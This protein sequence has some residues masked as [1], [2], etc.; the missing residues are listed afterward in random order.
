MRI[1]PKHGTPLVRTPQSPAG[2]RD[3]MTCAACNTEAL[4]RLAAQPGVITVV[5]GGAPGAPPMDAEEL[6]NWIA[7][8]GS[9]RFLHPAEQQLAVHALRALAAGQAPAGA[10][11][12]PAA[13]PGPSGDVAA[14]DRPAF[15][16][17][18]LAQGLIDLAERCEH[19]ARC[20]TAVDPRTLLREAAIALRAVAVSRTNSRTSGAALSN[21]L[22]RDDNPP[23][24]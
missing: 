17:H 20:D 21:A 16:A 6:A 5:A 3:L 12:P 11:A 14:I 22:N 7:L 19:C 18:R 24:K 23:L 1:C 15:E 8:A 10:P 13:A 9:S 2:S 4:D